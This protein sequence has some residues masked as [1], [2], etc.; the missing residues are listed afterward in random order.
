MT[1]R[2]RCAFNRGFEEAAKMA[3]L[4]ADEAMR[5][6]ADIILMRAP[7]TKFTAEQF[8]LGAMRRQPASANRQWTKS[9]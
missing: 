3:D 8:T 4:Y 6:A 7:P 1:E 5:I 9:H 2:E